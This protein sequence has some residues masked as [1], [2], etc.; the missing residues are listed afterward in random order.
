MPFGYCGQ[1][2]DFRYAVRTLRRSRGFVVTAVLTLAVGIAAN[3]TVVTL[4]SA[5]AFRT[6]PAP[7]ADRLVRIYPLALDGSR[8]NL[9]APGD[10]EALRS[11][12]S[13]LTELVGYIPETATARSTHD[14]SDPREVLVYLVSGNYFSTLGAGAALGRTLSLEDDLPSAAPLAVISHRF[15]QH[16]GGAADVLGSVVMLNG[17]AFT[18]GGV[19]P[20][21]FVG[22][23][24][25]VP[26]MWVPLKVASVL[27]RTPDRADSRSGRPVLVIGRLQP[28]A[29]HQAVEAQLSPL[30]R[31]LTN[32]RSPDA[33]RSGVTVLRA[34]FFPIDRDPLAVATLLMVGTGL[35]LAATW[36][37]V[38]NLFLT[39]AVGRQREIAVRLSL[40][41][42]RLRIARQFL[43]ESLCI[44]VAAG[45]AGLLISSWVLSLLY[46]LAVPW[47]PFEWGTVLLDLSPDGAVFTYTML[48]GMVTTVVIGLV[49]A[50]RADQVSLTASLHGAP[51]TASRR[52]LTPRARMV[53]TTAQVAI[54]LALAIVA[55]LL[56]RAAIHADALELGFN[57]HGVM[58]TEYDLAR[59]GYAPARAAAFTRQ[60]REDTSRVPGVTSV[61]LASH[62]PLT[63]GLRTTEVWAQDRPERS[64][65][66]PT[67]YV[68]V[69]P[70]Y[71]AT[72]Q[73]PLA[74]GRDVRDGAAREAVISDIVAERLWPDSDPLGARIRTALSEHEYVVVGVARDTRAR[75]LWRDKEAAVYLS[76]A[77]DDEISQTHLVVA[78]GGRLEQT[79]AHLRQASR[80][81]EPELAVRVTP[82]ESAVALWLLPSRAA[83][84]VSAVLAGVAL[85]I[86]SLGLFGVLSHLL[87]QQTRE[88]AI[89]RALG[90]DARVLVRFSLAQAGRLV[91]PGLGAGM[92]VGYVLAR[93]IATFLYDLGPADPIAYAVATAV[94]A[95]AALC[96][97][98]VPAR[99]A[100]RVDPMVVLR[101][102]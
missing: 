88:F 73:I 11:H 33:R 39:R 66:S 62:V 40:G 31:E 80:A 78:S 65:R 20:A 89:R 17:L 92:L 68:Y 42:G 97:C 32:P 26:D 72:L 79:A 60:L 45:A 71:F 38:T 19:A 67:R 2:G 21:T 16:L 50:V 37:N 81:L 35:L 47:M 102:E 61:A 8:E 36:A 14:G 82:L 77:A 24:P 95:C 63:G 76:A 93:L 96:A 27:M 5:L 85:L 57:P 23:E 25:L 9:F 10:Y 100:A 70:H 48:I 56:S 98:L 7:D 44:T 3:T 12:G 55:G 4:L 1:M 30:I 13:T 58:T 28:D 49:P 94:A 41:A 74:R 59:H 83:A 91:V 22:T 75:S 90:A 46:T 15:W 52:L 69:S 99:R 53:M 43:A 86:A 87:A 64:T 18:I 29:S 84:V 34:T 6:I 51:G 101:R 54:S